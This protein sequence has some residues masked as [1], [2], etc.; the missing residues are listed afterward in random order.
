VN[1]ARYDHWE[2][3]WPPVAAAML[4]AAQQTGAGLVTVSNLYAYGPV[5][6]SM[7]EDTPL[8]PA[9]TKGK[10]RAQMWADA[11]DAH[12]AGRLRATELRASDY[13]GPGAGSAVSMLNSFVIARAAAGKGVWL[14]SGSPDVPHSW[15]YLN[16]IGAL[17]AT[18]AT[19]DR[20]WGRVWHVPTGDPRTAR[21]V[22]A[23][24]ARLA[25]RP[26]PGVRSMPAPIKLLARVSATVRELDETSYQF[27]RPFVLDSELTRRTFDLEP[28]D[29][30]QALTG[31]IAWLGRGA[32][33]A[34]ASV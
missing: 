13:F 34:R 19:D 31:T 3:D 16:D 7:T 33:T 23:D 32:P 29:W 30:E 8:H 26:A 15:T 18:L 9:G 1:P 2:R 12:R 14:I 25:G 5:D 20:S 11:L 27:E 22:A 28:T 6:G 10:V 24:V 21:Q 17:A 4:A